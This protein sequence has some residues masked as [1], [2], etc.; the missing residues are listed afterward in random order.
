MKKLF[1][2]IFTLIFITY[3]SSQVVTIDYILKTKINTLKKVNLPTE[4]VLILKT[5]YGKSNFEDI[6]IV[7][8]LNHK[9]IEKIELIYTQNIDSKDFAQKDL[10]LT[11]LKYLYHKIPNIFNNN[12]IKWQITC[13]NGA[14]T[15]EDAKNYFHGFIIH[16]KPIDLS[17]KLLSTDEEIEFIEKALSEC[18]VKVGD[19][20]ETLIDIVSKCDYKYKIVIKS[21]T[22]YKIL[23]GNN[24]NLFTQIFPSKIKTI[25]YFDDLKRNQLIEYYSN[26]PEIKDFYTIRGAVDTV[27]LETSFS[28]IKKIKIPNTYIPKLKFKAQKGI[29]YT[30]KSIWNRKQKREK[31]T[32]KDT[33][34]IKQDTNYIITETGCHLIS[35]K[36]YIKITNTFF[37]DTIVLKTLS[38]NYD[39]KNTII[40]ED[41]TGSMYPY[42]TQ[43]FLWRRKMMEAK[44]I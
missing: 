4:N 28:K 29:T 44:T 36:R 1:F 43:T 5:E 32:I 6:D 25:K 40:I 37:K 8:E 14:P 38:K 15:I 21:D 30:K 11:R 33:L 31:I 22:F 23:E 41:L 7:K 13:Q 17:E 18:E 39:W 3:A 42:L 27:L 10:N 2:T 35:K 9:I 26:K 34:Y 16:F 12:L 19:T 24:K 20:V